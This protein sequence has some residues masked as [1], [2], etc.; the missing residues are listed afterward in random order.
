MTSSICTKF[1]HFL[2][3]LVRKCMVQKFLISYR[4]DFFDRFFSRFFDNSVRAFSYFLFRTEWSEMSLYCYYH[5]M[6]G[7]K[8][9][10]VQIH[11]LID[12][13]H[14]LNLIHNL[15][16]NFQRCLGKLKAPK[17]KRWYIKQE[18]K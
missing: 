15:S 11:A 9:R 6:V 3:V 2:V 8:Y 18:S 1:A 13:N 17:W 12:F 16:H 4:F 10:K 7:M 5:K 14:N